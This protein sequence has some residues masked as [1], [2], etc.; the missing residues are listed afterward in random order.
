L[1]ARE[2]GSL[3]PGLSE[4]VAYFRVPAKGHV[5]RWRECVQDPFREFEP[6]RTAMDGFD[7]C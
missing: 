2:R 1:A 4:R 3:A 5:E 6:V 7:A